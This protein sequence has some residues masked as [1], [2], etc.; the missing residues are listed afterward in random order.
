M[1]ITVT[2]NMTDV[3]MCESTTGWAGGIANLLLQSTAYIQG[4]YSLAAWINNTTSAVEY[5]TISAT[6]LVGQHVYVWMLC[7]GRVDTKANGGYRIVLYT[8][9]SNYAT[10]YVGGND[11]HGNGWNLLC[12]SADATPTAQVGTFNPASVTMIGIQFKTITTA[13]KQGQTYIQNCFWDAVRYGSGLTITSGA[14]DAISMEDIF[15][16]DDDVTYKYGVVQK[17]YGSYIIQGKLIFGGTGSESID[18][19]DSNQIVIFPDNPLVS[20]TFYGFVVQAGSGTT[21]FTLGVKSGT[22]GTSGCIFKAP[23]TKTYDLNLGNNNNNKVQLYGSSFVNAGLVTLPLSGANREVLNCS[24]NTSDGV[25]VSTCLMLNSNIISA[26]DEGVLLSNTS[27]QMSDSN[28]IDNPNAIRI[29]TA[30]EYDLDNV[31]FFGNTVDIDNT[32]GGAV[33]INCTNGSNPSTETG[34]TTIVNAVTVSVLVVDV[35]NTPINTAQVAIYKT[36]DKSELLNTDTDA[37]GLV[38][39]TFNYLTDTN[40]YF[41]IRKSSTGGTKYVPVSSSGTIT[42]TGFSSTITLLQDTTATI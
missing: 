40:I 33:V 15:A 10:F 28:F 7:N 4:T 30:G 17:S 21:N 38:Q 5:Y 37:N 23:G 25:I 11:T 9:A 1:A 14:T 31:K 24:F 41:R 2:P 8:D 22:V 19:V 35:T 34:D 42:S 20:D 27:H 32:S 13:T 6:S 29:D 26:D 36:S 39:T 16:V 18:F 3:S 12:C